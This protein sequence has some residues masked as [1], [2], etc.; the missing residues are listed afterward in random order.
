MSGKFV[1][2]F[3][4]YRARARCADDH[5]PMQDLQRRLMVGDVGQGEFIEEDD[6]LDIDV[7]RS[8]DTARPG[9]IKAL[10]ACK[11]NRARLVYVDLGPR[12]HDAIMLGI[13]DRP[14]YRDLDLHPVF[15]QGAAKKAIAARLGNRKIGWSETARV[16]SVAK[17]KADA[18]PFYERAWRVI[19]WLRW[20]DN[21]ALK[22]LVVKANTKRVVLK[23]GEPVVDGSMEFVPWTEERVIQL[24][25]KQLE[26]D[27]KEMTAKAL[28]SIG[29]DKLKSLSEVAKILDKR[30]FRTRSGQLD[31]WDKA[32]VNKVI[33]KAKC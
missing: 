19:R 14:E 16:N 31:A 30:K 20:N 26:D 5:Q 9:L 28:R 13:L 4:L 24:L 23:D 22:A 3:R 8:E 10:A 18:D 6:F 12:Y 2:Y 29:I 32:K 1:L 25:L 11:Q 27:G 17:R 21:D 7:S 33:I 15:P